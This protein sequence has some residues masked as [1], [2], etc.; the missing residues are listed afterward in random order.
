VAPASSVMNSRRLMP[1]MA[2]PALCRIIY[3]GHEPPTARADRL[4]HAQRSAAY[5]AGLGDG[6]ESF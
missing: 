1:N 4:Q 2:L 3:S 6:P 5:P